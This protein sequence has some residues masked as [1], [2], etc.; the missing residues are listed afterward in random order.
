M[1]GCSSSQ[2]LTTWTVQDLRLGKSRFDASHSTFCRKKL[3]TCSAES[4]IKT[5]DCGSKNN[6][7]PGHE[8]VMT[9]APAPAASKIRVGG[10]KPTCAMESRFTLRTSRA[11]QLM[12]LWS[13]ILTCPIRRT[14]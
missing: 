4:A 1:L 12:A 7:I 13:S 5:S 3:T 10:E 9:Q 8:S 2:E 6:S 11:E 14:F